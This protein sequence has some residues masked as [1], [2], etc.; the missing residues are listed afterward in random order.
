MSLNYKTFILILVALV[1]GTVS[2]H[3]GRYSSR[4]TQLAEDYRD[5]LDVPKL[6]GKT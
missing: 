2:T 1:M 3:A 6:Y 4:V 5:H